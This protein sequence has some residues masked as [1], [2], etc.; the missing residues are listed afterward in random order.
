[1]FAVIKTGGKQYRVAADDKINI[2]HVAGNPGDIITFDQVIMLAD[3]DKNE[4]G[5]PSISGVSVA[6]AI[7]E[8]ARGPKVIAFKKRRRK[9]S[10]RK[11]GHKQDFTVVQ[12]TEILT[13]GAKP[14]R[15]IEVKAPAASGA[16]SDDIELIG[17]IGPTIGQRLREA[18]ITTWKQVAAWTDADI[19]KY[20]EELSLRGRVQREEW[21][22]QAKELLAGKPPRAKTD[23]ERAEKAE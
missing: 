14:S 3:G 7:L 20:D 19:A 13:G 17:G 15:K 1:M 5:A 16:V 9:H 12:I 8:Q 11:R 22:E 23:Q 4:I 18:G 21:V 6:A 10:K 2:M